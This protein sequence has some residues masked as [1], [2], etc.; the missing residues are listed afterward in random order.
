MPSKE[1]MKYAYRGAGARLVAHGA[2]VDDGLVRD[3]G[4][5]LMRV[6]Q[7]DALPQQDSPQQ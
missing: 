5:G 2:A 4:E 7:R 6:D 3:G 1:S